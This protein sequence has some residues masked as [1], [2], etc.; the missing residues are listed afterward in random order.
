M[1]ILQKTPAGAEEFTGIDIDAEVAAMDLD[2]DVLAAF[3]RRR[4]G[5]AGNDD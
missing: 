3:E 4:P 5:E 1:K 2:E